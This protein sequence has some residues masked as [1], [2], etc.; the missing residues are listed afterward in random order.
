MSVNLVFLLNLLRYELNTV[1]TIIYEKI[2]CLLIDILKSN[3]L[4]LLN[5]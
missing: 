4:L 1:G 3:L 2:L 5:E